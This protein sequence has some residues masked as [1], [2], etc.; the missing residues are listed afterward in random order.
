MEERVLIEPNAKPFCKFRSHISL[1]SS[2][3]FGNGHIL[4]FLHGLFGFRALQR[5]ISRGGKKEIE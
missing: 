4:A 2:S 1:C 5:S 3:L